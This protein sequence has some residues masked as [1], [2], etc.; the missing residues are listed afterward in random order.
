M[1]CGSFP[2]KT[3]DSRSSASLR[4]VTWADQRRVFPRRVP[5]GG[6]FGLVFTVVEVGLQRRTLNAQRPIQ[7]AE[8][9][10]LDVGCWMLDV[11][12]FPLLPKSP[13]IALVVG[14]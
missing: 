8:R 6:F 11:G 7:I 12:R 4:F 13:I 9:W 2:L 5:L 14:T 1:P 3:S 10:M